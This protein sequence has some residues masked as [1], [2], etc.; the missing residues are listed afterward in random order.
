MEIGAAAL[1]FC[2]F[3]FLAVMC[4]KT[5]RWF[6]VTMVFFV[7]IASLFLATIAAVSKI[8]HTTWKREAAEKEIQ[9]AE[10]KRK[11]QAMS[12][13]DRNQLPVADA[14]E[15]RADD[16]PDNMFD[17]RSKLTRVMMDRGRVWRGAS[18][19]NVTGNAD[20]KRVEIKLGT[21]ENPNQIQG[22]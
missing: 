15:L 3:V 18:V 11:F 2:V 12:R 9:L 14:D 4:T 13:G 8:T 16:I 17:V 1:L 22:A 21:V 7:F 5:W 10:L 6:H 20:W 19:Q